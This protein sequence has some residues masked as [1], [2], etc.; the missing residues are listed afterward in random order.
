MERVLEPE[1]MDTAQDAEEYD[2][3]DFAEPNGRFAED[4]LAL[5]RSVPAAE[6]LDIGT[7][8]ADIPL[9]MLQLDARVRIVGVDLAREMLRLATKK[10]AAAGFAD[11]CRLELVDAKALPFEPGTFDL[12]MSNSIAH[13]I[14][15]PLALFE[16]VARVVKKGGAI[17][18]RDLIRPASTDEARAIVERVSPHDTTRQKQLFFDSLCAA[19]TLDEVAD[20][21]RRAGL[22]G[23]R[24]AR[25]SDRHWTAER[26]AR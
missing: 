1:V 18:V 14:P 12:V 20:L 15:E 19:L 13:H 16:Q 4:A 3:M 8:T 5:V 6:V 25:V 26:P 2:A 22:S 10:V 17:I 21:V 24:I 11:R 9:R 23:L 7:G